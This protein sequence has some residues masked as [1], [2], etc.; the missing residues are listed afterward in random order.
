VRKLL[1]LMGLSMI[2]VLLFA[3]MAWAQLSPP[4]NPEDCPNWRATPDG[5]QCSNLP[6]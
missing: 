2:G 3:P 6:T 1:L 4:V 5:W